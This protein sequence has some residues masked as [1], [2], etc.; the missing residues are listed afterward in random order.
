MKQQTKPQNVGNFMG[1]VFECI[2]IFRRFN[3]FGLD[4]STVLS[5]CSNMDVQELRSEV[6]VG[7]RMMHLE[8][9]GERCG[10]RGGQSLI[11]HTYF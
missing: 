5:D 3:L 2:Y 6:E 1:G 10:G 11:E 4:V 9:R 7:P 8:V